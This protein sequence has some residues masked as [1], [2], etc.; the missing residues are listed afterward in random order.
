MDDERRIVVPPEESGARLD[1]F[2]AAR[3][4]G[5]SRAQ[6][7]RAIAGG[8][9]T[10]NERAAKPSR[11]LR[12]GEEV[13]VELPEAAPLSATPE[14]IPL[15]I[16]FEDDDLV[17]VNK[18][19]GMVVHPGAGVTSGTLANALIHHFGQLSRT[20]GALRPGIVHRLDVGTSGLIV[21]AKTDR[22][23]L[24]LAE[25]FAERRV[26]KSYRA[27][28]YGLVRANEGR[29]EAPIGRDPRNRVKMAVRKAG[30]GRAAL[31]FYRVVERFSEFTLLDVE[32]KTGRT[33]QIRV[34]LAHLKHPVVGDATYDGGRANTIRDARLRAAVAR[35]GRP[36]LH[37]A[38]LSFAH[39][40]SGEVISFAAPLPA[41]LEDCLALA[42]AAV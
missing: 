5:A 20:Q 41:E 7:Q 17:V 30:E 40:T 13:Q 34:H 42:R 12:A 9:V 24:A 3:L 18:P 6:I 28:A 2:L 4:G 29:V 21:V 15:Q 31:T 22:A 19:A 37:A 8:D 39:P 26:L 23:H 36:F 1:A 32:I 11:R 27:L 25:Q 38:R 35:L 33:H 14:P 16:V 10:V